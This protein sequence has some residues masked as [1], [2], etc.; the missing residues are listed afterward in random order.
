MFTFHLITQ[1]SCCGFFKTWCHVPEI[2]CAFPA[3]HCALAGPRRPIAPWPAS[4]VCLSPPF[5]PSPWGHAAHTP[6]DAPH[7]LPP[8]WNAVC[9][10]FTGP[11]AA[12]LPSETAR[13]APGL[14]RM[15]AGRLRK[16]RAGALFRP[17]CLLTWG[18]RGV[19]PGI[20]LCW[21]LRHASG[22]HDRDQ[23]STCLQPGQ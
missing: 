19:V 5:C 18:L 13:R 9:W 14:D 12:S 22:A 6:V 7:V 1:Q 8:I 20:R 2:S 4:L 23:T 11:S 21:C 10:L 15:G 3:G 16:C 17:A